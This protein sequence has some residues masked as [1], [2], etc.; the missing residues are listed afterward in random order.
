MLERHMAEMAG[1]LLAYAT[2]GLLGQ[3]PADATPVL[4]GTE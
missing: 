2:I 4:L 1:S 3:G